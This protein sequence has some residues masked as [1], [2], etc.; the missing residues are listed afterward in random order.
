[1][2][3]TRYTV[4]EF[5][6]KL[7]KYPRTAIIVDGRSPGAGELH[8]GMYDGLPPNFRLIKALEVRSGWNPE[9]CQRDNGLE[10]ELLLTVNSSA[11]NEA[12]M[13]A[14]SQIDWVEEVEK[15]EFDN[16]AYH[17]EV[18]RLSEI[19]EASE[20]TDKTWPPSPTS[21]ATLDMHK[22]YKENPPKEEDNGVSDEEIK[23][24]LD[25]LGSK[26]ND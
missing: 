9:W 15:S 5:I 18:D 26:L 1:M 17:D 10:P 16:F 14:D 23:S 20:V 2:S 21:P 24:M 11:W 4:G 12:S 22:I 6:D 7:S 19:A 3:C 8:E 13:F 25:D